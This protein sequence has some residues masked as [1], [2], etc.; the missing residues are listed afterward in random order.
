MLSCQFY[1]GMLALLS[2]F[3]DDILN[4]L[5][6]L[7][8]L[9]D[10]GIEFGINFLDIDDLTRIFLLYI[11][12]DAEVGIIGKDI[13]VL[14][15][16]SQ[17]LLVLTVCKELHNLLLMLRQEHVLVAILLAQFAGVD[18]EHRAVGLGKLQQ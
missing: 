5:V 6:Q 17:I 15:E 13:V 14:N 1:E 16:F 11:A 7:I 10:E 8:A 18:E 9:S 12:G 2:Y 3:L 4:L